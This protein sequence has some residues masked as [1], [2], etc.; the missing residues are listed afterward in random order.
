M[1]TKKTEQMK[2]RKF[3]KKQVAMLAGVVSIGFV[4]MSTVSARGAG[5]NPLDFLAANT[6]LKDNQIVK[7]V[8]SIYNNLGNVFSLG[9]QD[10]TT[11]TQQAIDQVRGVQGQFAPTDTKKEIDQK[12][13]PNN[14]LSLNTKI[15]TAAWATNDVAAQ[16]VLSKQGQEG[17]KDANEKMKVLEQLTTDLSD[18]VFFAGKFAQDYES[19]QEVL[20]TI[21]MQLSGQA[22]I[23]AAQ[24]RL[25]VVQNSSMQDLKMN[26]AALNVAA[27]SQLERDLGKNQAE[28]IDKWNDYSSHTNAVWRNMLLPTQ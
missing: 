24:V 19:S 7:D 20:K 8:M 1:K 28:K 15:G 21:S 14:P 10:Y 23:S 3:T 22:D 5:F 11:I 17:I 2:T 27:A 6:G 18:D 12:A 26:A 13:D 16:Q 9:I 25:S 4:G